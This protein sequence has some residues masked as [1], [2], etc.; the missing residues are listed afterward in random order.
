MKRSPRPHLPN[1][2]KAYWH[3]VDLI[4]RVVFAPYRPVPFGVRAAKPTREIP[5]HGTY[6]ARWEAMRRM[7][8][9]LGYVLTT[10]NHD[11]MIRVWKY[12]KNIPSEVMYEHGLPKN[13]AMWLLEQAK[14]KALGPTHRT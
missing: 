3:D 11:Y 8:K 6:Q 13:V 2:E 7:A 9:S 10:S 5:Y 14:E 1:L 12:E 4:L